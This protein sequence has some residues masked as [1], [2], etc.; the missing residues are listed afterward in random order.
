MPVWAT[1]KMLRRDAELPPQGFLVA[2]ADSGFH[3][4]RQDASTT[5][6]ETGTCPLRL[7]GS[8]KC[9]H[10]TP[11]RL[12]SRTGGEIHAGPRGRGHSRH[13][14]RLRLHF[15]PSSRVTGCPEPLRGQ[16][17]GS[18]V[19]ALTPST[20]DRLS[21]RILPHGLVILHEDDDLIVVDKPGGLL[22]MSTHKESE[23]TAY[24]VMM[25][26]VRA[27]T[28]KS[29]ERVFIVHRLDRETS[30]VLLFARHEAA[31]RRIQDQWDQARKTY[32]ALVEGHPPRDSGLEESHLFETTALRVYSTPD[33]SRG[34][35][36]RT[37]WKVLQR[38]PRFS[39][40]EVDLL[41]GRKH[42]IRV[43]L[44]EMGYPVVGDPKYGDPSTDR[45]ANSGELPGM[46]SR[47][48]VKS[49]RLA[50]HAWRLELPH[51]TTG[52]LLAVEA[53]LP[54]SIAGF[55]GGRLSG[56]SQSPASEPDPTQPTRPDFAMLTVSRKGKVHRRSRE[57]PLDQVLCRLI[58]PDGVYLDPRTKEPYTGPWPDGFDPVHPPRPRN[59]TLDWPP[60][61][62]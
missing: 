54:R 17:Y 33:S 30:G 38:T 28:A 13:L 50:L 25:D 57:V 5:V 24:W 7:W 49:P 47:P 8:P 19:H 12:R 3:L 31:Q 40:L 61:G 43:H 39:L 36:A 56:V 34:A 2:D 11:K 32:L 14:A 53:P 58:Y 55:I 52:E 1:T 9:G 41:T 45:R 10:P 60:P 16:S 59:W 15:S 51:P 37:A 23:R 44:A 6:I 22:T 42:Q 18:R 35:F 29:R 62:E 46:G 21:R 27:G 48:R 20:P 26:Y 4:C